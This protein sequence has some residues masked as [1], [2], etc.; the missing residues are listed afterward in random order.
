MVRKLIY[1][2]RLYIKYYLNKLNPKENEYAIRNALRAERGYSW[3]FKA[4]CHS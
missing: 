4:S 2:R 1:L 3:R